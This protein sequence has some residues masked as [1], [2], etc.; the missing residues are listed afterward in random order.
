M[1]KIRVQLQGGLGNQLFIWAM[2]HELERTTGC[3]IQIKYVRDKLQ[4]ADRPIEIYSLLQHC[5]HAISINESK[6]L[7]FILRIIDKPVKLSKFISRVCQKILGIYDCQSSSEV[8]NFAGKRPR[9]LR[10]YFQ[11]VEMVERNSSVI[12]EELGAALEMISTCL[13]EKATTVMHIR[14]G[15]T[16]VISESWGVLSSAYYLKIVDQTKS[17]II[18]S[19]DDSISSLFAGEFPNAT[20]LSP[21]NS[22]TWEALKILI[23]GN[24]LVM[25][26]STLSWWAGWLKA[27]KDPK[28]VFFPDP[29]RPLERITF[30]NLK[31]NSVNFCIAEFE[32]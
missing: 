25:A 30:E 5:N 27:K 7:G 22:S 4:R 19:D 32:V 12:L 13:L 3:E 8:P 29:C 9:I 17:L 10:G 15:D 23:S 31:L 16:K 2:A 18:C 24:Q 20:F 1:K 6:N 21:S 26:N 14:R 11:N 28:S